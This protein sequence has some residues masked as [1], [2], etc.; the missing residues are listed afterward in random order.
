MGKGQ[1]ETKRERK[2]E[3]GK[4]IRGEETKVMEIE[5]GKVNKKETAHTGKKNPKS[6]RMVNEW[7]FSRVG[8]L[9]VPGLFCHR[10]YNA[11]QS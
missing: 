10:I 6:K 5:R 4:E 2:E 1:W 9:M 7:C 11:L 3:M 8:H